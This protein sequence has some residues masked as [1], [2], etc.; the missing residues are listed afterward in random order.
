MLLTGLVHSI[1]LL[2]GYLF[3]PNDIQFLVEEVDK[4]LLIAKNEF[5]NLTG[6]INTENFTKPSYFKILSNYHTVLQ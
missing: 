4:Q 2:I 3:I 5:D 6:E 1:F